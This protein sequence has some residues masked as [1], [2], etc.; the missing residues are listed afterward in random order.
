MQFQRVFHESHMAFDI[1]H[2][3][4]T[5]TSSTFDENAMRRGFDA[6]MG[7]MADDDDEDD[8][9][10]NPNAHNDDEF[11][12]YVNIP[13]FMRRP[14]VQFSSSSSSS[15]APRFG[16]AR[17]MHI[18]QSSRRPPTSRRRHNPS[19]VIDLTMDSDEDLPPLV[20]SR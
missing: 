20:P 16:S 15:S 6:F 17:V 3:F 1:I 13:E 12:E 11:E 2:Q 18:T 9:D 5:N 4:M 8:D 10:F 7:M 14:Y 19:E